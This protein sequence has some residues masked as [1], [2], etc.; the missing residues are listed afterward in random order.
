MEVGFI[1][2]NCNTDEQVAM[3]AK[4]K[5]YENGFIL[6]PAVMSPDDILS[7]L[8]VLRDARKISG[9]PLTVDGRMGSKL[10]GL[11]SNR[12]TDF[13]ENRSV[14]LSTVMTPFDKLVCGKFP[15]M[16]EEAN[17]L[18]RVSKKGYL[19]IVDAQG[20]LMSLTTRTDL[21]KEHGFP[22]CEQG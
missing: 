9:V 15:L 1:H 14:K 8:D 5:N 7:D 6:D 12:D 3:V 19:P 13:L 17:E 22:Q 18:L 11:V 10:V 2:S 16:I 20:N 4:V 21:R